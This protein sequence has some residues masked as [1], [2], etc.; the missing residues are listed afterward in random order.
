MYYLSPYMNPAHQFIF[1]RIQILNGRVYYS[2]NSTRTVEEP[3]V[4]PPTENPFVPPPSL[5]KFG[6]K[7]N[8]MQLDITTYIKPRWWTLAWGWIA[9]MPHEPNYCTVPT[10]SS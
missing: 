1:R 4:H 7:R 6:V 10:I 8:I 9:F 2:P 5:T 3:P